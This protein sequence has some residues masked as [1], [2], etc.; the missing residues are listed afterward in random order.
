VTALRSLAV[1][2]SSRVVRWASP[3]CKEWAEGL[4]REAAVIESDWAA[5]RWAIGSMRVVLD[6]REAPIGSGSELPARRPSYL[7][8]SVWLFYL[9]TGLLVCTK[10]LTSTGWPRRL[11]WGLLLLGWGY[12]AACSVFDWLRE[13]MQPPTS[14]I[15]A[16]RLFLRDGLELKLARYRTVSRW[17]PVLADLSGL[18]GYLLIVRGEIHF[19]GYFI[20]LGW[21]SLHSPE[22]P[23]KIQSRI[24]RMDALI[25]E[26][27]PV[28]LKLNVNGK[29]LHSDHW[30]R[31]Q[32]PKPE[33]ASGGGR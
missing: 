22:T 7:D 9:S 28:N 23:S 13:R 12:W 14:D 32:T 5:L 17:F 20:L 33:I 4:A 21:V 1:G 11:G 24:E 6:R 27:Q 10:M 25:A 3:G 8:V 29:R 19:W 18:M 26:G 2:I 15:V 16:Y 30:G 31:P